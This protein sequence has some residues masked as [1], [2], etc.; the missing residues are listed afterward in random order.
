MDRKKM[1]TMLVNELKA[2]AEKM[3]VKLPA[4]AKKAEIIDILMSG[5]PASAGRTKAGKPAAKKTVAARKPAAPKRAPAAAPAATPPRKREWKLPPGAEEPLMAQEAV[6]ES[7]FYTGPEEKK[8]APMY[9]DL[10]AGYGEERIALL[11]RDPYLAYAYWEATPARLEREKAWFGWKSK[12]CVRIYDVTGVR[13]DGSN[14]VGYYDQE[15]FERLGNWYFDLGRPT[16]T[17]CADIGLMSPEGRFL[18]LARSNYITMPRDG[19]SDIVD[20]EWMM[21]DEEFW[22]L[23]GFPGGLSS[24]QMQEAWRRRRLQEMFS[25]GFSSRVKSKGK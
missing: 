4:G 12:L 9:Q 2:L 24:P 13:F 17:F 11:A 8:P 20:E 10:P 19:V 18:T 6:A 5:E 21:V 16:H 3:K 1:T 23:Y 7:K 25:P 15:V 22:K 14:A